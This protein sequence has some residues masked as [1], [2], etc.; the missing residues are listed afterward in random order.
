MG[1]S[2]SV[3]RSLVFLHGIHAQPE[4]VLLRADTFQ[5][6]C[7]A[8]VDRAD[9]FELFAVIGVY[10]AVVVEGVVF[11]FGMGAGSCHIH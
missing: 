4:A 6:L 5:V 9:P 11:L 8:A 3:P 2:L 10:C 7:G 1:S